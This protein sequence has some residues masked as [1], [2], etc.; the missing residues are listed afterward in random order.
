MSTGRRRKGPG[1]ERFTYTRLVAVRSRTVYEAGGQSP[2]FFSLSGWGTV[3]IIQ[4]E[5]G[6]EWRGV[7]WRGGFCMGHSVLWLSCALGDE[8]SLT[9]Y[10]LPSP[11]PQFDIQRGGGGQP[12]KVT[13]HFSPFPFPEYLLSPRSQ[14][15]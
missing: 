9:A 3:P 1:W 15:E 10:P 11:P 12:R 6:C 13:P 7:A 5:P 8:I 2:P 14:T 4:L